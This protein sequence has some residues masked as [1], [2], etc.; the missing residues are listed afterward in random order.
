[1]PGKRL[2]IF[3]EGPSDERL[4]NEILK[5]IFE[6]RLSEVGGEVVV[7]QYSHISNKA[8]DA[9][10]TRIEAQGD[11]YLLLKDRE[12]ARCVTGEKDY[13]QKKFPRLDVRKVIIVVKLIEG[14]YLGG[15][16]ETSAKKLKVSYVATT[17]RLTKPAFNASMPGNFRTRTA[18]MVEILK[19][20]DLATARRK[21]KSFDYFVKKYQLDS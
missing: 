2:F 14:W 3:V 10:F 19:Y 9:E 12:D 13:L 20:F 5:P 21:N 4:V 6:K 11:D 16:D 8:M 17:D 7:I 1:M 18:Y 15:L